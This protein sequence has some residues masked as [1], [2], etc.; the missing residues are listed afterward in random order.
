MTLLLLL[1]LAG[2]IYYNSIP[3][4]NGTITVA[5]DGLNT[6]T[7]TRDAFGIPTIESETLADVSY[8]I[9]YAHAQDR[10]WS[11]EFKRKVGQGRLSEFAGRETLRTDILFRELRI[12]QNSMAKYN[13]LDEYTKSI[14]IS[15]ANGINDY[16]A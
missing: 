8:G 11:I 13:N 7:I 1:S 16:V 15:Y 2:F 12:E 3:T 4:Y 9:G 6:I 10:L 14:L 5:R